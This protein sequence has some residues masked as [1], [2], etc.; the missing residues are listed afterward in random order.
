MRVVLLCDEAFRLEKTRPDGGMPSDG[1]NACLYADICTRA[2]ERC[3]GEYF[4]MLTEFGTN[5]INS[6]LI[7]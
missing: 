3:R 4:G 6:E 2:P 5:K 1:C 7:P